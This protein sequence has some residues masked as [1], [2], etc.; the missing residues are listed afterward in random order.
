NGSILGLELYYVCDLNIRTPAAVGASSVTHRPAR[1]ANEPRSA[2]PSDRRLS[3]WG[4]NTSR[5][6]QSPTACRLHAKHKVSTWGYTLRPSNRGRECM[7][8][9]SAS[10]G[11]FRNCDS[12]CT[13]WRARPSTEWC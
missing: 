10:S 8:R 1:C 13:C 12:E 4:P 11:E 9:P 2:Q 6:N 5:Y 7:E 3:C